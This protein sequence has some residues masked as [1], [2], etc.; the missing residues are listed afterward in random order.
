[1]YLRYTVGM[2]KTFDTVSAVVKEMFSENSYA[3]VKN[4]TEEEIAEVTNAFLNETPIP[5]KFKFYELDETES[6]LGDDADEDE[7]EGWE[8]QDKLDAIFN[9]YKPTDEEKHI[10]TAPRIDVKIFGRVFPTYID[11]RGV[12]RFVPNQVVDAI[13]NRDHDVK[14]RG[15]DYILNWASVQYQSGKFS[16]D[17]F[18]DFY[19]SFGYS[20]SSFCSLSFMDF[21]PVENPI[22]EN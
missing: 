12:Q 11:E 17:D 15:Y 3:P 6:L 4:P 14:T 20:V 1:M 19:T 16:F 8:T 18:I 9:R 13:I 22:W 7:V 10:A 2:E 5:V 21:I